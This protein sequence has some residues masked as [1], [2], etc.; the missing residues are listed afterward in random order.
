MKKLLLLL[1]SIFI[2][3]SSYAD[4]VLYCQDKLATGIAK[5]DNGIW[6]T[7]GF[8]NNRYTIKFNDDYSSLIVIDKYQEILE[9]NNAIPHILSCVNFWGNDGVI[10]NNN[11]TGFS[12]RYLKSKKRYVYISSGPAGYLINNIGTDSISAGTCAKF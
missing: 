1:F 12:F 11:D 6:K 5:N 7:E 2:S 3:L 4:T 10:C 8:V 9:E